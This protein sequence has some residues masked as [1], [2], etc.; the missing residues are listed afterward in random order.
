MSEKTKVKYISEYDITDSDLLVKKPFKLKTENQRR[1]I[2][3]EISAPVSMRN[4]KDNINSIIDDEVYTIDGTIFNISANGVLV[5]MNEEVALKDYILMKFTIQDVE[6]LD[7]IL[8]IVKRIDREQ[9]SN[10][11]GIEF[12][13]PKALEDSLSKPEIELLQENITNFNDSVH[14]TLEKYIYKKIK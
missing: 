8:G 4:L 10:L 13:S 2:R 12:L 3:I 1:F 6:V 14:E 7:S 9:D 11:V 5:E